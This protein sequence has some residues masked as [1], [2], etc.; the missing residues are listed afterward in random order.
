ME[1]HDEPDSNQEKFT[2]AIVKYNSKPRFNLELIRNLMAMPDVDVNQLTTCTQRDAT[3]SQTTLYRETPLAY[4][5]EDG[6]YDVARVLL[7]NSNINPN[8]RVGEENATPLGVAIKRND[9]EMIRL[10]LANPN[11]DVNSRNFNK[12]RTPLALAAY[13][14]NLDAVR[15]LLDDPRV[16]VNAFDIDGNTPLLIACEREGFYDVPI[17]HHIVGRG[18]FMIP[19][20]SKDVIKMLLLDPRTQVDKV[21][22]MTLRTAESYIRA[23]DEELKKLFKAALIRKNAKKNIETLK[24][25]PVRPPGVFGPADPGGKTYQERRNEFDRTPERGVTSFLNA[26]K[27]YDK[28]ED[29]R[30][31]WNR[32]LCKHPGCSIMGGK[33]RGTKRTRKTRGTKRTRKTRKTRR[34]RRNKKHTRK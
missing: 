7:T 15:L 20:R 30:A 25:L 4:A 21:N 12:L 9:L 1:A 27:A 18:N 11:I 3:Q 14:H 6:M 32:V 13:Y 33:T 17:E 8:I 16:K 34:S 29:E 31:E 2:C 24:M 5:F 23:D 10:L 22:I 26:R 19:N 28:Q